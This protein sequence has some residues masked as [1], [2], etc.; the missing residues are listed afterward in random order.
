[1]GLILFFGKI[2]FGVLSII[3]IGASMGALPTD[4]EQ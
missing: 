2:I 1:M 3:L 4:E